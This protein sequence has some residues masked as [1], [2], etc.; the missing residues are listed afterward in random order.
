MKPYEEDSSRI[1]AMYRLAAA[2]PHRRVLEL[3]LDSQPLFDDDSPAEGV[4]I[5][6]F[7]SGLSPFPAARAFAAARHRSCI[8]D[9]RRPLPFAANAF[10]LVFMHEALDRL[11][12]ADPSLTQPATLTD[13]L[14]RIGNVLV[15][16]GVFAASVTNRSLVSRWKRRILRRGSDVDSAS[17]LFSI[18]SCRDILERCGFSDVQVFNVVPSH[19]SPLRLINTDAD[20][21]R[22]AFRRELE[23]VRP[24]LPVPEYV[25]RRVAAEFSLDRFLENSLLF[26]G[27]KR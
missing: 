19:R 25:V 2:S 9:Y 11:I 13:F 3:A 16:G 23:L 4:S 8:A 7:L 20:L 17:T 24:Y 6:C 26:W 27:R 21:A 10:D 22:L 14:S 12:G 18:G 15:T 5:T 1:R